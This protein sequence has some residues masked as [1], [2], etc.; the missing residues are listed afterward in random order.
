MAIPFYD[1]IDINNNK[2]INV[3][4]PELDGDS[5][6]KKY[7]DDSIYNLS[8]TINTKILEEK[9]N[10]TDYIDEE[11]NTTKSLITA[12]ESSVDTKILNNIV[13]DLYTSDNDK[14]LS[15]RQGVELRSLIED[16]STTVTSVNN[17]D[18]VEDGEIN[19][20][21]NILGLAYKRCLIPIFIDTSIT[22]QINEFDLAQKIG[23]IAVIFKI[24]GFI[25]ENAIIHYINTDDFK[26]ID[27]NIKQAKLKL[28]F[29]QTILPTLENNT[30]YLIIEYYDD[31]QF[32][33]ENVDES[34]KE[35][36]DVEGGE[37]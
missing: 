33:E 16:L 4:T 24:S 10:I 17:Y 2:I 32:I 13:D 19:I 15:A 22:E 3:N 23:N 27:Y 30:L 6:N 25:I 20:S 28:E 9:A 29:S 31:T 26:V 11:I 14:S 35:N 36:V 34:I 37:V 21:G 12:L 1:N 18:S 5:A 7:V 8:N